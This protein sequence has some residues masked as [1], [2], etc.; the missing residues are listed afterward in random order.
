MRRR[1]QRFVDM[2]QVILEQLE[3]AIAC[4]EL[5]SE[6]LN[7]TFSLAADAAMPTT[8]CSLVTCGLPSRS[9]LA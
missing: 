9:L 3:A 1:E 2:I 7:D 6:W 8:A 4:I 5:S